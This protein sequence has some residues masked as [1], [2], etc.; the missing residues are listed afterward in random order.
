MGA[1]TSVLTE[2]LQKIEITYHQRNMRLAQCFIGFHL[3]MLWLFIIVLESSL[4]NVFNAVIHL[5]CFWFHTRTYQKHFHQ[6]VCIKLGATHDR[7][8]VSTVT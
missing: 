3:M 4:L 6:L 5:A 2:K 1:D 7:Q 8:D